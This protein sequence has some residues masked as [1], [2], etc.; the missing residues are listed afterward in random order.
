MSALS[1]SQSILGGSAISAIVPAARACDKW[2][3]WTD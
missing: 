3:F 1:S 2:L